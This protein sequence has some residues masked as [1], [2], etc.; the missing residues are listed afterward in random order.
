M[1]DE[2]TPGREEGH[3]LQ[4]RRF[5]LLKKQDCR[6][7]TPVQW[8]SNIL[9]LKVWKVMKDLDGP[10][11][12]T[13]QRLPLLVNFKLI[14]QLGHAISYKEHTYRSLKAKFS[15]SSKYRWEREQGED[16]KS[17]LSSS[18][19][20]GTAMVTIITESSCIKKK[21]R[22]T[23]SH[24]L[25]FSSLEFK[26]KVSGCRFWMVGRRGPSLLLLPPLRPISGL[27]LPQSPASGLSWNCSFHGGWD[28][29]IQRVERVRI[30][31]SEASA[32]LKHVP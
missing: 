29:T 21:K 17:V 9:R 22:V 28:R 13:E 2:Q 14:W 32:D 24:F 18:H 20:T 26:K 4:L 12:T 16:L 27:S 23:R 31:P 25:S 10:A 30:Q 1:A 6:I 15:L 3:Q 19:P 11:W 5:F 7:L 8:H